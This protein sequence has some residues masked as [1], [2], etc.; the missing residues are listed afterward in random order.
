MP[1]S[2]TASA[3]APVGLLAV[4]LAACVGGGSSPPPG[5]GVDADQVALQQEERTRLEA[6]TRVLFGWTINEAGARFRGRGVARIEPPYRARLDLFLEN[7]EP[8][9]TAALVD[10]D[11]RLPVQAPEGLLPPAPLLWASL[12]VFR[13]G[14][15][16]ELLGG[17]AVG[18]EATR[19]R[20]RLPSGVE[21][22]YELARDRIQKAELLRSGEVEESMGLTH[23]A[24][25][26][27]L[28]S[29]ATYRNI[30]AFRQLAV[31]AERVQFVEPYPPEIWTVGR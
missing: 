9:V 26:E 3:R 24:E 27:G 23:T 2:S 14:A 21:L 31:Q 7:G 20:Y 6:P 29:E 25:V 15:T 1:G 18:D 10:D 16:A 17:E 5:P 22:H 11:L 30:A 28:P 8:I 19:L 4:F 13:P 12:G